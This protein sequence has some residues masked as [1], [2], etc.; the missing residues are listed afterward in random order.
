LQ[1]AVESADRSV[2]I[3]AVDALGAM[4][5]ERIVPLLIK[6]YPRLDHQLRRKVVEILGN[7]PAS[8][9]DAEPFL[10]RMLQ[11]QDGPLRSNAAWALGKRPSARAL[12]ALEQAAREQNWMV[13]V[14]ALAALARSRSRA[15]RPL[16]K[17]LSTDPVVMVRANALLGWAWTS[18]PQAYPVLLKRLFADPEPLIR[19]NALRGLVHLRPTKILMESTMKASTLEDLLRHIAAEDPHPRVRHVAMELQRSPRPRGTEQWIGFYLSDIHHQPL[20]HQPILLI[21]PSGLIKAALSDGLGEIWE[22]NLP[23]GPS[24]IELPP[25]GRPSS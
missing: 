22:E 11:S 6:Q 21:T 4:R 5:D 8:R 3:A 12:R 18:D 24:F 17:R 1:E 19:M 7:N 23:E 9:Q 10:L 25:L 13:R 2:F 15:A 16:F 14:N 20:R